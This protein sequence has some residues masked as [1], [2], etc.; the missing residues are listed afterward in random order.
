MDF[1]N[2]NTGEEVRRETMESAMQD[3]P[4][5]RL[6]QRLRQARLARNLTQSE[7]AANQFSVSYISAV[8]R[9][10]IRPSLGAL[11]KLARRLQV[12]VA[13]LLR[14]EEG[15]PDIT[16]P[17]AEFFPMGERDEVDSA[18]RDAVIHLE[19][20]R[21][22]DALRTLEAVR[23]RGL[24]VREQALVL[25][26]AAQAERELKNGEDART[27]GQEALALADRL[28]DAELRERIRLELA[29]GL[30]LL[31]KHQAA[32]DQ[33]RACREAVE[34]GTIRDPLFALSVTYLLGNEEWHLGEVERAIELLSQA[35][36]MANDILDPQR[37]GDLYWQLSAS[38][39]SQGDG[40]RARL[41][42]TRSLAEYEDAAN[43]RMARRVLTRLG[44]AYAQ[45]GQLSEALTHLEMARER[46]ELQQDARALSEAQ[47]ALAGIYLRQNRVDD[48]ARAA[49]QAMEFASSLDDTVQQAEAQLVLAQVLEAKHD[50]AGAERNFDQAI[51]RLRA[52]DALHSLSDAYAQYSAF[53]ERRGNNKK[54]LEILKQ[55]WQLRERAA[56]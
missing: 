26:R 17:P 19:Q 48:A 31:G 7:V 52:A 37:L 23:D 22:Q 53:L 40:R 43:R 51:E 39:R 38:Y 34:A 30:S 18:L 54:A 32:I 50:D 4:A 2:A 47:A 10:Q 33:L 24:S 28:G 49:Q 21:P 27:A 44:R 9:G 11:E 1:G 55:A 41:Y 3:T 20:G 15:A 25:W 46:A 36:T 56:Q 12:S 35:A 6:G 16:I 13:D 14:L 42:A 5:V 45:A 8:E 29:Q